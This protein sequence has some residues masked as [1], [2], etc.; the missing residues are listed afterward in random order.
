MSLIFKGYKEVDRL[1]EGD[2]IIVPA[3][4]CIATYFAISHNNLTPV[5]IDVDIDTYNI[6]P[7]LIE[8]R[9]TEKT[10]AIMPVHIYGQC[11]DMDAINSIAKKY[12]LL[13]VEDAAQA[14]GAVYK[15]KK[16]G[17][18]GYAAGFSFYPGKNLGAF[19]DGGAVTTNDAELAEVIRALRN[20]GST[21]KYIHHY[22][23]VNSRLDEIQ[24]A[25]LNVKLKYLDKENQSRR[26]IAQYYI[27]NIKNDAIIQPQTRKLDSEVSKNLEHV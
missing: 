8:E 14:H 11:T 18:L 26:E 24:A 22:K 2:E 13:V 20:Y 19:G 25:I 10:K 23:G 1:K 4:S 27:E 3:N 16:I 15:G 17:S 5:L 7:S 9:I 21:E 6:A 12:N